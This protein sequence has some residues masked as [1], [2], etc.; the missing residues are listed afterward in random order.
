MQIFKH[1]FHT[2]RTKTQVSVSFLHT[3]FIWKP[4]IIRERS[5][6][7]CPELMKK[8]NGRSLDLRKRPFSNIWLEL[9]TG[10]EPVTYALPRRC[11]TTCATSA[12]L[13]IIAQSCIFVKPFFKKNRKNFLEDKHG[14]K[15]EVFYFAKAVKISKTACISFW[16]MV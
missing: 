9:M 13:I 14:R 11:A 1:A 10:F 2:D 8:V 6:D 12:T 15:T 5:A 4:S 7:R 16:N 3:T